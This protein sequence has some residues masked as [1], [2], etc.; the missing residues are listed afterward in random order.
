MTVALCSF[1]VTRY[2]LLPAT[3][4]AYLN[5]KFRIAPF[6]IAGDIRGSCFGL[7]SIK[8]YLNLSENASPGETAF[9]ADAQRIVQRD[10]GYLDFLYAVNIRCVAEMLPYNNSLSVFALPTSQSSTSVEK[11]ASAL[12]RSFLFHK[13]HDSRSSFL[14]HIAG[15]RFGFTTCQRDAPSANA[16][17]ME[18]GS[19][20]ETKSSSCAFLEIAAPVQFLSGQMNFTSRLESYD[21][22]C[23]KLLNLMHDHLHESYFNHSTE[24]KD[25]Q[26]L[27]HQHDKPDS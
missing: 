11:L 9:S 15:A 13:R 16:P 6:Q 19:K 23:T 20:F 12:F 24:E 2:G 4:F 5:L 8:Q 21:Q 3:Y 14:L 17:E 18:G 25:G 10:L 22:N 27:L 26:Y 1:Y 7:P